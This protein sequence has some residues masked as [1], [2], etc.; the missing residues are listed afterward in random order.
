MKN[1]NI[2]K[3]L[4]YYRKSNGLSVNDVSAQL[5][6]KNIKAANKTIYGWESGQ[7]Q[8]DAD[9]LRVLCEIYR[10]NNILE[11]FGYIDDEHAPVKLTLF[12]EQLIMRYREKTQMQKAIHKLLDL[13]N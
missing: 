1:M 11:T 8:P 12:E 10:I 13:E 4:K 6:D 2:S 3:V 9:T 7:T 5:K